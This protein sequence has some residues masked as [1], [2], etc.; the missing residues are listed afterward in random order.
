MARGVTEVR[1]RPRSVR[2]RA[3]LSVS[4]LM[5][6]RPKST[7]LFRLSPLAWQVSYETV[8]RV[9]G[10]QCAP[11]KLSGIQPIDDFVDPGPGNA[12]V[13]CGL[14]DRY[15]SRSKGRGNRLNP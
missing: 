6:T 1:F 3:R 8:D 4:L 13:S 5:S 15:E 14:L 9:F 7:R 11:T 2:A 10:D 12:C